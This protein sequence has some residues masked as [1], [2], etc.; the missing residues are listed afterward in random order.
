M[1]FCE[2]FTVKI[3][4]AWS[5][6]PIILTPSQVSVISSLE[7]KRL[8]CLMSYIIFLSSYMIPPNSEGDPFIDGQ[9]RSV[10]PICSICRD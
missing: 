7:T 4:S 6:Q 10:Q 2:L 3:I 8:T 9:I 5:L 1:T